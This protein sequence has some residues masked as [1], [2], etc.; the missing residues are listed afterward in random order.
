MIKGLTMIAARR[1][2]NCH[3]PEAC[4]GSFIISPPRLAWFLELI[5]AMTGEDSLI[6]DAPLGNVVIIMAILMLLF[7]SLGVFAS[8]YYLR[9]RVSG[10][11]KAEVKESN[12]GITLLGFIYLLLS[13]T[14][15]MALSRYDTR[16]TFIYQ[17]ANCIG[18][19][20]LRSDLYPDSVRTVLR[21]DFKDYVEARIAYYEAHQVNKE[22]IHRTLARSG[23]ISGRIWKTAI[24]TSK[25]QPNV[26]RDGQMIPALNAMIDIVTSRDAARLAR[27]P[28]SIVYLLLASII[29]GCFIIGYDKMSWV[30][31][32]F[33][34]LMTLMTI[35]TILDLDRPKR[36][37]IRSDLTHEKIVGLRKMF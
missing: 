3:F 33:F 13:F 20:I 17:E 34:T 29:I 10:P 4:S 18:T 30:V 8:K 26:I 19:A 7:Y 27:V 16:R 9:G 5:K 14:F 11:D 35:F 28:D 25:A 23:E 6:Y 15:S 22:A 31:L 32:A 2:V 1:D 12:N 21:K 24:S 36:G 37:L